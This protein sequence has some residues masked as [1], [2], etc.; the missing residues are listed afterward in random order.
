MQDHKGYQCAG[1][2]YCRHLAQCEQV[3]RQQEKR[4]MKPQQLNGRTVQEGYYLWL[5]LNYLLNLEKIH[6]IRATTI[7]ITII[8]V[9][10]PAL[11]IP[12]TSSHEVK[13][14]ETPKAR[15]NK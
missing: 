7:T 5:M 14:M 1:P 2:V 6:P 3:D 9:Q 10:K 11:K 15:I 12:S 4:K 8:A 13:V